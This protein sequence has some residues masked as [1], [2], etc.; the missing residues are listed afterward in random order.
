MATEVVVTVTAPEIYVGL[1]ASSPSPNQ[2]AVVYPTAGAAQD[3]YNL[4][5]SGNTVF[6]DV[7]PA[8][9]QID[10]ANLLGGAF[11]TD[12][13]VF[14]VLTGLDAGWSGT[15]TQTSRYSIGANEYSSMASAEAG[16][17]RDLVAAD[18][19]CIIECEA[20]LDETNAVFSGWTADATRHIIIRGLVPHNGIP[21]TGYVIQSPAFSVLDLDVPYTQLTNIEAVNTATD[22]SQ[23]GIAIGGSL[24]ENCIIQWGTIGAILNAGI[25][26]TAEGAVVRNNLIISDSAV[27]A[28][29]S[30]CAGIVLYNIDSAEIYNNTVVNLGAASSFV[31]IDCSFTADPSGYNI[32]NNAVYGFDLCFAGGAG[33]SL[34]NATS[35]S[36]GQITGLT[37]AA[38][39]DSATRNFRPV[40]GGVL[41]S[42]GTSPPTL[43][44][45]DFRDIAGSTRYF[46]SI[47]AFDYWAF[48]A[49]VSDT[50]G[51]YTS[52][53]AAE[54]GEQRDLVVC[55]APAIIEADAFY[56]VIT[57]TLY[58]FGWGTDTTNFVTLRPT[59]GAEHGGSSLA[60]YVLYTDS[61]STLLYDAGTHM[62]I[63][64]IE[65]VN[66]RAS[67]SAV[68]NF[69]GLVLE[70][71]IIRWANLACTGVYASGTNT[72]LR[73]N[74]FFF[75]APAG[76]T[77]TQ[78]AIYALTPAPTVHNNTIL[79]LGGT[80][81]S[82]YRGINLVADGEVRNNVVYGFSAGI[83]PAPTVSS[84]NATSDWTGEISGITSAVFADYAGGDYAAAAGGA[85]AGAGYDLSGVF[86]DDIIRATRT[87]PWDIGAFVA[88]EGGTPG[89]PTLSDI[90]AATIEA[91]TVTPRVTITF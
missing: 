59:P 90:Q 56:D 31:G 84:N 39:A 5:T 73:N 44:G 26:V 74:L 88:A 16:E 91:T 25:A 67:T 41:D 20:F 18:E 61:A 70:R 7:S 64:D 52:L 8:N 58:W 38:F 54:A 62:V 72:I 80:T 37:L 4:A 66:E 23:T 40:A 6:S 63:Q 69:S 1:S 77:L 53:A 50:S 87:V 57:A 13:T 14:F 65:L 86:D 78:A 51:D 89:V 46:W 3:A 68:V 49:R 12:T 32:Q 28:G 10:T 45:T 27:D 42:A 60:G 19:V 35:D 11:L 43:P 76:P 21:G 47:G 22:S 75:D 30:P 82:A 34:N 85:L 17:Q 29:G 71:C 55:D 24:I 9:P 79:Y 83:D 2:L 48:Y 36:L 81:H 33:T 15:L